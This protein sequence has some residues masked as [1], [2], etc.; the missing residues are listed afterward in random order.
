[1][2]ARDDSIVG[3]TGRS[4]VT[5]LCSP[6]RPRLAPMP[7]ATMKRPVSTSQGMRL[8]WGAF[9]RCPSTLRPQPQLLHRAI[10]TRFSGNHPA[11]CPR[12]W[13]R[14]GPGC[15]TH[16]AIARSRRQR[17]VRCR[18]HRTDRAQ[19]G[20]HLIEQFLGR[21]ICCASARLRRSSNDFRQW[22]QG[23]YVQ[24]IE[25]HEALDSPKQLRPQCCRN[26]SRNLFWSSAC[27]SAQLLHTE[28]ET[29]VRA[30]QIKMV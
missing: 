9:A 4:T 27:R 1:L 18:A 20:Q 21:M 26:P 15:G 11:A 29:V 30:P 8:F 16:P 19:A 24:G 7:S 25:T 14:A 17:G 5:T 3:A 12:R 10:L 23:L 2:G 22:R 6:A 28:P 13:C